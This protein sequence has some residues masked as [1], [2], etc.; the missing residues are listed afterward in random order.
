MLDVLGIETYYGDSHVLQGISL[1]IEA[2]EAVALLGRNGAGKTTTL[3][4]IM[5]ITA[6]RRGRIVFRGEDITGLPPHLVARRGIAWIPEERRILPNLTVHENLKLA[7]LRAPAN[8]ADP[9]SRI[10]EALGMFPR[11]RER[12]AQRGKGLSGGEQQML[13]IA[14]GLVA[15]PAL[16]LVDEPTEGLMPLVVRQLTEI[17]AT[18][19]ARGSAILLVEQN[20]EVALAL[21][22]RLYLIDQGRIEF[23]GSPEDLRGHPALLHRFL[24]V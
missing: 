3:K 23:E 18:I 2:G 5:G 24:G 19:N 17:L 11:L 4:S 16:M 1:R 20:M 10:E 15:H 8:G 7:L 22:R 12:I 6:P 14:R 13:A 9:E 21:A